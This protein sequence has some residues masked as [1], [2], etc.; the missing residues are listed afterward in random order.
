MAVRQGPIRWVLILLVIG[1]VGVGAAAVVWWPTLGFSST[2]DATDPPVQAT[3][4]NSA[5]CG[6]PDAHDTV[7]AQVNG[8]RKQVPLSG[9][10]QAKG[11][12]LNVVIGTGSNGQPLAQ[13]T[14]AAQ[15][16]GNRNGRLTALLMCLSGGAGALYAYLIRRRPRPAAEAPVPEPPAVVGAGPPV[17]GEQENSDAPV[18][19]TAL[20]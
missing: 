20:S 19:R 18:S 9:C 8:Q 11:T 15:V 3:V 4:V 2:A 13:A 5:Q 1:L 10:G 6:G 16:G 12:T 7:E 17:I 14:D